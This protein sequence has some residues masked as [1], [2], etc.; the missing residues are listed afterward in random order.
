MSSERRGPV[1]RLRSVAKKYPIYSRPSDKLL[2][3][4][5]GGRLR[6]HSE[7]WALEDIDLEVE[8]GVTVGIL[9]QNGSGKSTLLQIVAGILRQTRGEVSVEGT[10]AALLE[11]GAGFNPEF[12]G[13]DNVFM[14]ASILGLRHAEI[15]TRFAAI[16]DF[17]A[18]GDFIDRPVKTYSSGMFMRLAFAVA[19][20]VDP[21]I[22]LVDEALAVGDLMFQ[23]R[24]I[25]RI[26][27]LRE[28][29]RTILFVTHDLQA[30]TQ[31]CQRAVLL[32][33]GRKIDEGEPET[34]VQRYR[35]LIARREKTGLQAEPGLEQR[36]PDESLQ[37]ASTIPNV[38]HRYGH[39]GARL[40]GVELRDG[41]GA[42]AAAAAA[43]EQLRLRV[44]ARF[45]R[46]MRHP[47]IGFTVRDRMGVEVTASNTAYEGT[48]LPA[49]E[50][51][52]TVTVEF[53]FQLPPLR[54]GGYSVSPAVSE[55]SLWE[56]QVEDWIDNACHFE[57]TD[58]GLVYGAMRWPV[59]ISFRISGSG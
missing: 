36:R 12:S 2:E 1:I 8:A 38:D 23:H 57:L 4:I 32:D 31:F 40:V 51:G 28:E 49:V 6:R 17:A 45:E 22:L 10:V 25:N 44:S 9:G 13:R 18:I 46:P 20:H 42:V 30:V 55:G 47:I 7:F 5:S 35:A 41:S 37:A 21:R 43:G 48:A 50:A 19:V 56:H 52:A 58:T 54:P 59:E 14:N 3:L 29:G 33:R 11:L 27:R 53:A 34:V 16:E 15:E 24:C 39:G 26:R